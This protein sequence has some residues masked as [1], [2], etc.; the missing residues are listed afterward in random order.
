MSLIAVRGGARSLFV[1]VFAPGDVCE[2]VLLH[3]GCGMEGSVGS[4]VVR[5]EID[6]S[7]LAVGSG[8]SDFKC[9]SQYFKWVW[10]SQ[11]GFVC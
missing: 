9:G 1:D 7:N 10:L 6:A 8:V 4:L 5:V 11:I 3:G 2:V